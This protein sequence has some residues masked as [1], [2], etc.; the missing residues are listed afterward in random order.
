MSRLAWVN[1]FASGPMTGNPLAVVLDAG[2]WTASRMQGFAAELGI[3]ETAFVLPP[4]A[5]GDHRVR[6][7]T[8]LRELP[9]AGHPMVG[10]AWVLRAAGRI[11]ET[12]RLETGAGIAGGARPGLGGDHR[13][14][15]SRGRARPSTA[16]RWAG[17][18]A[19][20]RCR[21]P[22]PGCG[23]PACRS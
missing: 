14:G 11:G 7:F 23:A 3:S 18:S 16:P 15:P 22:R 21:I 17:R 19:S 5:D 8:P 1:V 4:E 9:I 12:A 13:A 2:Q 6:I 10:T 20:R